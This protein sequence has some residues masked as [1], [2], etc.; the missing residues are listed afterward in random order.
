MKRTEGKV[1]RHI[2]SL[3]CGHCWEAWRHKFLWARP[4]LAPRRRRAPE[5]FAVVQAHLRT[6]PPLGCQC[7]GS[8]AETYGGEEGD[9][10]PFTFACE[11]CG[12]PTPWCR[13][14][15]ESEL[16]DQCWDGLFRRHRTDTPFPCECGACRLRAS[17]VTH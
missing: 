4:R 13:G 5:A 12:Q 9:A 15:S 2:R 11:C 3:G 6:L 1:A 7:E 14:M 16:C 8:C 17:G 10:D